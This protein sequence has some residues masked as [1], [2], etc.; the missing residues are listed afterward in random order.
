MAIKLSVKLKRLLLGDVTLTDG[1]LKDV[2]TEFS[3][4]IFSGTIPD[5]PET[6][7]SGSDTLLATYPGCSFLDAVYDSTLDN[8]VLKKEVAGWSVLAIASGQAGWFRCFMPSPDDGL[9]A[10]IYKAYMRIDGEISESDGDLVFSNKLFTINTSKTI[11][12]F[13]ISIT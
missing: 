11:D 10:D 1:S 7:K 13:N 12:Q 3:I 9:V 6:A 8:V 5:S 2:L 4:H